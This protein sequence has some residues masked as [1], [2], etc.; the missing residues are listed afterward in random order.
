MERLRRY[1]EDPVSHKT[2]SPIHPVI[3]VIPKPTKDEKNNDAIMDFFVSMKLNLPNLEMPSLTST[4]DQPN[5]Q[6]GRAVSLDTT[7]VLTKIESMIPMKSEF[8]E[9]D[10]LSEEAKVKK[11]RKTANEIILSEYRNGLANA[12]FPN[13]ELIP[14]HKRHDAL[15]MHYFY[16]NGEDYI[17]SKRSGI[18]RLFYSQNKGSFLKDIQ[19]KFDDYF[20]Y[21]EEKKKSDPDVQR[22][23]RTGFQPFLHQHLIRQYLNRETPYRGVL[24]YHGLG[25]GKTCTSIGLIEAM[26]ETIPQIYI[27]TPASLKQNYITQMKKCGSSL[28]STVPYNHHLWRFVEYP[29]DE[30][31][32]KE[33]IHHVKV[34]TKLPDKFF[35]NKKRRGVYLRR[36]NF[37]VVSEE[38]GHKIDEK[39]LEEQI[40]SMIEERF[41]FI[42]YNGITTNSWNKKYKNK[43]KH[44]NPFNHSIV[45]IDE[46]HNFVSRIVNKLNTNNVSVSTM[47]Y[48]DL[49]YAENCKVIALSGTPL[50]NYPCELGV[51]FNI[52]AGSNR[53]ITLGI[54]HVEKSKM[55]LNNIKELLNPFTTIDY[56]E[57]VPPNSGSRYAKL[58]ILRN[59]YGFKKEQGNAMIQDLKSAS[60]STE[61][62]KETI[63]GA[64]KKAQYKIETPNKR[65]DEIQLYKS[66]PDTEMDFN[67]KFV[68]NNRL[69]NA[70]YFRQKIL[71]S[72]SYIGDDK[73]SMPSVVVPET[74]PDKEWYKGEDIFIEEVK[75]T[76]HVL[77]AYNDARDMESSMDKRNNQKSKGK[78]T[79]TSSYKLF[80]RASCN[81]AFPNTMK[82]PFP[83]KLTNLKEEDMEDLKLISSEERMNLGDGV[84][85]GTDLENPKIQ[86]SEYKKSIDRVL[87]EFKHHPER[88]FESEL[89]KL[90]SIP[91]EEVASH[92]SSN[93]LTMYSPKY[94]RILKNMMN[95]CDEYGV[96]LLYSNFRTLEGIGIFK[97][98]LDYYG[99]TQFQIKKRENGGYYIHIDNPYYKDKSYFP[100]MKARKFYALYTGTE[101]AEVK[102]MI[103]NIYNGNIDAITDVDLKQEIQDIFNN[104]KV[105]ESNKANTK[106]EIIELLMITSSGAEGIDL[107]NV[108]YVHIMEPYWH[109]VRIS[110]VIGRGRRIGSHTNLPAEYQD[111]KVYMYMLIHDKELLKQH[112]DK[113]RKLIESDSDKGLRKQYVYSTDES[114]YRIMYRKKLLMD[115]FLTTLKE[116]SVDCML[117]YEGK[118]EGAKC[119]KPTKYM[120][121]LDGPLYHYDY[122][123]DKTSSIKREVVENNDDN[124]D[125]E[126]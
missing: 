44:H 74:L 55:K 25:S 75:M 91:Q 82:R 116:T 53:V 41:K 11:K 78:D 60:L 126:V 28:F 14:S 115:E 86:S 107:K 40:Q 42:S 20:H 67:E 106:G 4:I 37:G 119:F 49:V 94:H 102:E 16:D 66:F 114:L 98:V 13:F 83:G 7:I 18:K 77:K 48:E 36:Y 45:I 109:A 50:I 120:K 122:K 113:Y 104:G 117:N 125:I 103:R 21:V 39:A 23:M 95:H 72:V 63:K 89:P 70:T 9:V 65:E 33:F 118:E 34:M 3:K 54:T 69:K 1:I 79:Q 68:N 31:E 88:Y 62:L 59:P 76:P 121:E 81:F 8:E 30:A 43:R 124:N 64:L 24:L 29:E 85:D 99:F 26:K 35:K 97:I 32:K 46:A 100:S 110:Q 5:Q 15:D 61:K 80:S 6:I 19:K 101:S 38:T 96:Q 108:R 93:Q 2:L 92:S 51:M 52:I 58:K 57:L 56:I 112:H 73:S 47:M 10:E 27:L 111:I 22:N 84:F 71:G 90:V 123:E 17:S 105:F 87:K 12:G